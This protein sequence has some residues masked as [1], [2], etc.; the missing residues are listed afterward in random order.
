MKLEILVVS[1]I[2]TAGAKDKFDSN[3]NSSHLWLWCGRYSILC[4]LF[5]VMEVLAVEE[6]DQVGVEDSGSAIY[7]QIGTKKL[8]LLLPL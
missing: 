3:L 7:V 6:V 1:Y 4:S 2:K 8:V 5:D